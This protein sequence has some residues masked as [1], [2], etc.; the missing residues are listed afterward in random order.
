MHHNDPVVLI[1]TLKKVVLRHFLF[2]AFLDKIN[3]YNI[4][5][6]ILP[7]ATGLDVNTV[8]SFY[9]FCTERVTPP[10]YTYQTDCTNLYIY[11]IVDV[12]ALYSLQMTTLNGFITIKHALAIF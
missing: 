10:M 12:R 5:F 7:S 3:I 9:L 6:D 4:S 2:L 1:Q 8:L 11:Y